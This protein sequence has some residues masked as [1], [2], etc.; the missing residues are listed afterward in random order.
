M[1]DPFNLINYIYQAN[2][3]SEIKEMQLYLIIAAKAKAFM[4]GLSK[5]KMVNVLFF[6]GACL[7]HT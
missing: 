5:I 2:Y 4:K 7:N 3:F 6:V 1:V